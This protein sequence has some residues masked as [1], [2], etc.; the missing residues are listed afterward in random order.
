M[1]ASSS[2][3]TIAELPGYL[4][5]KN[6]VGREYVKEY[7]DFRFGK[8]K[9]VETPG[10]PVNSDVVSNEAYSCFGAVTCDVFEAELDEEVESDQELCGQSTFYRGAGLH[11]GFEDREVP[12]GKKAHL[13]YSAVTVQGPRSSISNSTRGRWWVRGKRKLRSLEV[14]YREAHSLMLLGAVPTHTNLS[15]EPVVDPRKLGLMV[16]CKEE[17]E[18]EKPL[19]RFRAKKEEGLDGK[20]EKQQKKEEGDECYKP[21]RGGGTVQLCD[22]TC[23]GVD[24]T[25]TTQEA[26]L[27]AQPVDVA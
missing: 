8:P 25:W 5:S 17:D 13:I 9:V 18:D 24:G 26:P 19:L 11:G 10:G 22:L 4:V 6:F 16:N 1:A 23:D 12:E 27:R 21:E 7:R 20:E 14:R 2:H 15:V 3:P